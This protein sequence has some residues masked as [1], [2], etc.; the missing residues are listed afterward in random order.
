MTM[1]QIFTDTEL[2]SFEDACS[3]V[4]EA[5]DSMSSCSS[6]EDDDTEKEVQTPPNDY[7]E[8]YL[9]FDTSLSDEQP[10]IFSGGMSY[11]QCNE[12]YRALELEEARRT[13]KRRRQRFFLGRSGSR[14]SKA[15][16]TTTTAFDFDLSASDALAAQNEDT[17]L[18]HSIAISAPSSKAIRRASDASTASTASA[19]SSS[20]L[21][22]VS[23]SR[24]TFDDTV[25]VFKVPSISDVP[26]DVWQA[27]WKSRQEVRAHKK[28]CK[29]E[30][31]W[32]GHDWKNATEED[33]M[34]LDPNTGTLEHPVHYE[35]Y[36]V[37]TNSRSTGPTFALRLGLR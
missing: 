7:H 19:S 3:E 12:Y 22:S 18:V 32:D 9:P 13:S 29:K 33:D 35:G 23:C 36:S 6:E 4:E 37:C 25:T 15:A 2:A 28:L 14:T 11:D 8:L 5:E 24:I 21:S 16:K 30:Y 27:T 17:Q 34:I 26:E 20:S 31:A 10:I 1:E